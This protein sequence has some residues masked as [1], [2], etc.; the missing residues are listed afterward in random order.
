MLS[1]L[2]Q[3]GWL[4]SGRYMK[5]ENFHNRDDTVTISVKNF[6]PDFLAEKLARLMSSIFNKMVQRELEKN[7]KKAFKRRYGGIG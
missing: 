1:S 7:E 3:S 4:K 6:N 2:T 5:K